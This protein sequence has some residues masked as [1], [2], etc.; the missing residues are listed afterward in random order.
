MSIEIDTDTIDRHI[1]A[2]LQENC[3]LPLTRIGER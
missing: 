1:L 2:V 3:K